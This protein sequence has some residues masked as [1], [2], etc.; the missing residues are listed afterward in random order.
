MNDS[1]GTRGLRFAQ[2]FGVSDIGKEAWS[3]AIEVGPALLAKDKTVSPKIVN[4]HLD[5][6]L[7]SFRDNNAVSY[8][9]R[10]GEG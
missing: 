7:Q 1:P 4:E 2:V 9:D 10:I 6:L 3:H 5:P 8:V